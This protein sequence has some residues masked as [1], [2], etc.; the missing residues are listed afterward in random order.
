[1]DLLA[2]TIIPI[3]DNTECSMVSHLHASSARLQEGHSLQSIQS[4]A[5]SGHLLITPLSVSH[6]DLQ[7]L[8][9]IV[10]TPSHRL[11]SSLILQASPAIEI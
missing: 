3:S 8:S 2:V 11:I 9:P 5:V 1:M 6:M 7:R 10:E 4:A